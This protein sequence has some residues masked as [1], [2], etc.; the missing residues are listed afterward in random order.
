MRKT[1]GASKAYGMYGYHK[2]L[3]PHGKRLANKAVR[4]HAKKG[5]KNESAQGTK[6]QV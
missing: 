5:I 1:E 2:H 4:R 3:K 6:G